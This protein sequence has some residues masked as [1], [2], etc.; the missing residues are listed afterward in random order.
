[1]PARVQGCVSSIHQGIRSCSVFLILVLTFE[2]YFELRT[3]LSDQHLADTTL[4]FLSLTTSLFEKLFPPDFSNSWKCMICRRHS[5]LP[6]VFWLSRGGR[7][8]EGGSAHWHI[9]LLNSVSFCFHSD[10]AWV[11]GRFFCVK[12]LQ[13]GLFHCIV[14]QQVKI[15][16]A[17]QSTVTITAVI[18]SKSCTASNGTLQPEGNKEPLLSV[19]APDQDI[20]ILIVCARKK[21]LWVPLATGGVSCAPINSKLA[22]SNK[23][24]SLAVAWGNREW[25]KPSRTTNP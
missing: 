9:L 2:N 25:V 14:Y 24:Y 18:L 19:S 4:G 23:K 17:P 11:F 6:V 8:G 10:Q 13:V 16:E 12:W 3:H 22:I 15:A 21:G 1:M 7:E 5:T 20:Y